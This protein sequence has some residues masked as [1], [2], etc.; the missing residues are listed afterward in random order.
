M[1]TLKGEAQAYESPKTK[2]IADLEKIPVD[3]QIE[4]REF[5]KEDGSTF[6]VKVVVLNEEDYR[7][8]T[9]VLKTLKTILE[10]KPDLKYFKVKKTGEGLKT[11]YTV[12]TL[13]D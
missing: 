9:S 1:G 13:E 4:E 12:I 8:P 3:L 2:N 11:E 5:T 10:E 7:V 6:K